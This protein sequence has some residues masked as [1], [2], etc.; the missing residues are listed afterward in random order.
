MRTIVLLACLAATASA[1]GRQ[2]DYVAKNFR[3]TTGETLPEIKIPVC[4]VARKSAS[5]PCAC[6][7]RA[8]AKAVYFLP[9]AQSVPTVSKR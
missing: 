2:G 8:N 4:P 1:Q 3:F 9:N 5:K 6:I 7:S